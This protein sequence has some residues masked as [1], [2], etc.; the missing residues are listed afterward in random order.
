VFCYNA[1]TND[2]TGFTP[3]ELIYGGAKPELLH[4]VNLACATGPDDVVSKADYHREAAARLKTAYALVR[5]QQERLAAASRAAIESKRGPRQSK[6]PVYT[7]GDQ[8]LFWEPVQ[9]KTMQTQAQLLQGVQVVNAPQK[10]RSRWSGPHTILNRRLVGDTV[11][12]K[13]YHKERGKDLETHPN[14]LCLFQPW[15]VGLGSTSWDI[16]AKRLYKTGEWVPTGSLV[17]VPMQ[18]PC[19]FGIAKVLSCTPDGDLTL[20]WLANHEEKPEGT[21]KP[22]WTHHAK[23]EPYFAATPKNPAHVA[24]TTSAEGF[25]LNQHDIIMHG[26]A[27]TGKDHLPAPLLRAI[28]RH[29]YVWWDPYSRAPAAEEPP[30]SGGAQAATTAATVAATAAAAS[31]AAAAALAAA[32]A[33]EENL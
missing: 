4:L 13:F 19:P 2:A 18:E 29:P 21:F 26:F 24:Y 1:S 5:V 28:A 10:W 30:L 27:L 17:V 12:Y 9:P 20:Q 22:G 14:K 3:H 7:I 31:T 15:A 32:L 8:V 33:T 11:R 16:D 6:R 25:Q 23:F